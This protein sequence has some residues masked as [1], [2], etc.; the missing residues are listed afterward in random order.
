MI[1][2]AK[3]NKSVLLRKLTVDD[4]DKLSHYLQNLGPGTVKRYGPHGFDKQS[5]SELYKNLNQYTGY[6]A[7][8][9][10]TSGI[11]AY[12]VIKTGYLE[13]DGYRLQS[14]GVTPDGK[15]DCTFAPSVADAWQS[16]G[17]GNSLFHFMLSDLKTKGFKRIILWGGVQSSNLKAVN[18]YLKNGFRKLGQFEHNGMNDDMILE[19]V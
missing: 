15:T 6:I 8:D 13:H 1:V 11:I 19:I 5:V 9:T 4:I 7:I 10:E 14:Y 17:L 18:Y 12:S 2:Q 16:Q 3:N